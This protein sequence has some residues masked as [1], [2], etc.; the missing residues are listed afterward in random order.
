MITA[1]VFSGLRS[2]AEAAEVL[3]EVLSAGAPASEDLRKDCIFQGLVEQARSR[4]ESSGSPQSSDV[5]S[6]SPDAAANTSRTASEVVDDFSAVRQIT[7]NV[8]ASEL[9]SPSII[10][11]KLSEDMSVPLKLNVTA[12][13]LVAS[14]EPGQSPVVGGKPATE[15][16]RAAK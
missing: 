6:A 7:L 8:K 9:V 13:E 4:R 5:G 16:A 2:P 10:S 1:V 12:S 14:L 3:R 15:Q 11:E